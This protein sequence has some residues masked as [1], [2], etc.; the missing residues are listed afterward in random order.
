MNSFPEGRYVSAVGV[1]Q[2][3][4]GGQ[5]GAMLMRSR[6]LSAVRGDPVDVLTFDPSRSYDVTRAELIRAGELSDGM[7]V[8]NLYEHY[9]EHGWGDEAATGESLPEVT[10]LEPVEVQHTDGSPWRT[11]Y[12]DAEG[13]AVLNDFRRR[14]GSIYLR[15]PRYNTLDP[16]NWPAELLRVGPGGQVVGRFRSLTEWYHR[17][18]NDL[19]PPGRPLFVFTDS[20]FVVP[21]MAPIAN[22]SIYLIYVMHNCHV[23]PPRTWSSTVHGDYRRC[24]DR[25]G[26]VDALV[27][28]TRRQRDDIAR[29]WG[30]RSTLEVVPNPV[31]SPPWPDP[32][33]ARDPFRV[34]V[35][36]R[37]E[38]QKRVE[39]AVLAFVQVQAAVP[40]AHLDIFGSGS[41]QPGLQQLVDDRGLTDHVT[42]HGYDPGA[43]DALWTAS[44]FLLTSRYEGYPLSTLESLSRGC[45]VV[46]YD[47]PYGPREQI[48][49]GVD[50]YV[51][52]DADIDGAAIRVIELLQSPDLVT[53]MS[54]A[55]RSKALQHDEDHFLADWAEVLNR[56]VDRSPRRVEIGSPE[57][58]L[59]LQDAADGSPTLELRGRLRVA[60]EPITADIASAR[61]SLV[62]IDRKRSGFVELPL[63]VEPRGTEFDLA[64]TIDIKPLMRSSPALRR[65]QLQLRLDWENAH[66]STLVSS[67]QT[68]TAPGVKQDPNGL[69][70]LRRIRAAAR[71][72]PAPTPPPPPRPPTP[73]R[74][75][76]QKAAGRLRRIAGQLGRQDSS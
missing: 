31:Q 2:S 27:T 33:P 61:I 48:T 57:L 46:S 17:W 67:S 18:L 3:G 65:A 75:P 26:D 14:D 36:A 8:L 37:L 19:A 30:D 58:H 12:V 23:A 62:A 41:R 11:A 53:R 21:I 72:P 47:V 35:V 4:K 44:V 22:Q 10:G 24:L 20:R 69:L 52:P 16:A 39:H 34:V 9:R 32:A 29:R 54:A 71:T 70:T 74:T 49:D 56:V 51:V 43:R 55:A 76:V 40:E 68:L 15:A 1:L 60:P 6:I 50:G 13:E 38:R 66:W 42:L 73:R 45:P 25:A 5:T 7:R 64:A 59:Q 63:T 28:L